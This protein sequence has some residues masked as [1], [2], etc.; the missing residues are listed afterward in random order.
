MN[1]IY[2]NRSHIDK[3]D[4]GVCFVN[5]TTGLCRQIVDPQGNIRN[6]P[7]VEFHEEMKRQC[8]TFRGEPTLRHQMVFGQMENGRISVLWTIRPEYFDPG[9]EWGFGREEI[10]CVKMYSYLDEQGNFTQPFRLH[11]IGDKQYAP[12][13]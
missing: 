2:M 9:D 3:K 12:D 11:S 1:P 5:E 6:F 13:M 7:G 8:A 4:P 10:P